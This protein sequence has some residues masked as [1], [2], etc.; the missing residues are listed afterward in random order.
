MKSFLDEF[1]EPEGR[2]NR[3]C[4][5]LF[6]IG[7]YIVV[8]YSRYIYTQSGLIQNFAQIKEFDIGSVS[9]MLTTLLLISA[10]LERALEVYAL[11][12]REKGEKK[13]DDHV[14]KLKASRQLVDEVKDGSDFEM[15]MTKLIGTFSLQAIWKEAG[16]AV[17]N[18]G[19]KIVVMTKIQELV[20]SNEETAAIYKDT[21]RRYILWSALCS[22]IL[23]SIVGVRGLAPFINLGNGDTWQDNW[24]KLFDICLTGAIIAGGSDII[25]KILNVFT[26]FMDAI[27]TSNKA[28][29]DANTGDTSP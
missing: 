28:I 20:D 9:Q 16:K 11:T 25:H 22:G 18:A 8:I 7:M 24:F 15:Q 21:T 14:K 27:T 29:K 3:I 19:K 12:F 10:F 5:C 2:W 23:I 13:I 1:T 26:T 6:W 4:F 17:D